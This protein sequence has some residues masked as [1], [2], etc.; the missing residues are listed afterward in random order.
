MG[1]GIAEVAALAG[2]PTVLYDVEARFL[3]SGMEKIRWSLSKLA[4]K[5]A[6]TH[7][8]AEQAAAGIVRTTEV[9]EVSRCDLIIEAAPENLDLKKAPL[10]AP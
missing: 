9:G 4:E 6:I 5:G 8:K 7:E 2:Y 3:D 10:R 1:H